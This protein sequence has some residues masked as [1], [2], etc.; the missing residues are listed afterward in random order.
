MDIN[1]F[2]SRGNKPPNITLA[3]ETTD[4]YNGKPDIN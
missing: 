4:I 1:W 3:P 2:I